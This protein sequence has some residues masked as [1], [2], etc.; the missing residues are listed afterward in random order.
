MGEKKEKTRKIFLDELPR[1]GKFN[2]INW[3]DSVGCSIKFIYDDI[4]GIFKIISYNCKNGKVE[5]CYKENNYNLQLPNLINCKLGVI[6][7]KI[8][9]KF[10]YKIGD[11]VNS[12]IKI[13][14]PIKTMDNKRAYEYKCIECGNEDTIL[15]SVI[16][17]G[18]SCNVCCAT[19]KKIIYGINSLED[20]HPW[21]V[22]Y[23]K[24]PNDAKTYS[25]GTQKKIE[26]VCKECGQT[27]MLSPHT[28]IK[29]GIMCGRCGDGKSFPNKIM[30]S[31]LQQL[32]I[33]FDSEKQF[34]WCEFKKYKSEKIQKGYYDFYFEKDCNKYIVE[35]DGEM[36]HGKDTTFKTGKETIYIDNIKDKLA[37]KHN[38]EVI[39][40]YSPDNFEI[41]KQ[42]I[43]DSKLN[44]LFNLDKISWET[45]LKY[46]SK[47]LVF[48]AIDYLNKNKTLT[49]ISDIMKIC[50]PTL[51][52]YFK[53]GKEMGL[54]DYENSISYKRQQN[55]NRVNSKNKFSKT[56][57]CFNNLKLYKS[58]IRCEES[59]KKDLGI[60]I[61]KTGIWSVCN[62][63]QKDIYGFKFKY[64]E[65]LTQEEYIKYDI[66]IN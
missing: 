27:K 7:G 30:F 65:N 21:V 31:V 9:T 29:N 49:E 62:N 61:G 5:I 17:L 26:F 10:K 58:L 12:K 55:L 64:I 23:L 25:K 53:L 3:V 60:K 19:P 36:G 22:S 38:I 56:L 44:I 47:S 66:K 1:K 24:N 11:L 28:F 40:I 6:I 35:M 59:S 34:K 43:L 50:K 46:S 39:R 32:K 48:V 14:K 18:C 16:D 2:R 51:R 13:T 20:T 33:K 54:C 57:I 4:E 45:C 52:K 42:N 15:E 8:N 41:I 37:N 63:K